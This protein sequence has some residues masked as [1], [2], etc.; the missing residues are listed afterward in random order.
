MNVVIIGNPITDISSGK[1]IEK[2]A[3]IFETLSD[4]IYIVNDGAFNLDNPKYVIV[5]S[6]RYAKIVKNMRSSYSYI[7]SFLSFV[8]SQVGSALG[9]LK[10]A[11]KVDIVI[12]F[13]ITLF[14]PVIIAKI[15]GKEIVLYQAQDIFSERSD[16]CL[17]AKIKFRILLCS[18]EVVLRCV[19]A[20]V[21]EGYHV[22]DESFREKYKSK[23]HVCPQYVYDR[24]LINKPL[25][26]RKNRVGF[27]ASL[28]LRK[29][30]LEFARA[31]KL[32]SGYR[33]ISFII[34]GDGEL[35]CEIQ[36]LLAGEID[37]GSVQY[38]DYVDEQDFTTLLSELKLLVLPSLSEG[39]PNIIIESMA[40]GTPVL[41][42]P[43]GA[44]PDV[45]TDGKTGFLLADNQPRS[46]AD[47]IIRALEAPNLE[48]VAYNAQELIR[49]EYTQQKVIDRYENLFQELGVA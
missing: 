11:R 5:P 14:L 23:I 49:N 41:A 8:V 34:V 44:I 24:Y 40:C 47:N 45:I 42:T 28:T 29:G 10:C 4:K 30:A 21:I 9:F 33:G 39:L 2:Y 22:V 36:S 13:P 19:T 38:L 32:L 12:V 7:F 17:A 20:I 1:F 26:L 27:V 48:I 31:I 3:K 35:K 6:T 18:R 16:A 46:I 37:A 25:D 15:L 43:V